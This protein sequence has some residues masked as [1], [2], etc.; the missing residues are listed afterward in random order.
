MPEPE[1]P[2]AEPALQLLFSMLHFAMAVLL[3]GAII[4]FSELYGPDRVELG[5]RK[6]PIHFEPVALDPSDFGPLRLA[7]AWKLSAPD[8]RFGGLSALAVSRGGLLA[9]SDSGVVFRFPKPGAARP[10]VFIDELPAGPKDPRFKRN[11]DTESLLRDWKGRGWWVGFENRNQVWLYDRDFRQVLSK[12]R[13]R[14]HVWPQTGFEAVSEENKRLLLVPESGGK[15]LMVGKNRNKKGK[16]LP[17]PPGT[18]SDAAKLPDG[19]LL[20]VQRHLSVDGLHNRL[21]QVR[22]DGDRYVLVR[23]IPL[24]VGRLDNV[25][26][27]AIEQRPES[28]ALR[29][30]LTT[31]DGMQWPQRTLLVALDWPAVTG[32]AEAS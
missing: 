16:W 20:L 31:D 12:Y 5:P 21:V 8:P 14:R 11:R 13:V 15:L 26:G 22:R 29:L 2:G 25:E 27:V 1:R 10:G 32:P 7:G 17:L 9:L 18:V 4:N 24:G 19:S 6:V 30:W 3:A 23:S 28:G